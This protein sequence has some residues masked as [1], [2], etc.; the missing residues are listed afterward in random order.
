M[1]TRRGAEDTGSSGSLQVSG[2]MYEQASRRLG[3]AYRPYVIWG[4]PDFSGPLEFQ[5]WRG[6]RHALRFGAQQCGPVMGLYLK[7]APRRLR[8]RRDVRRDLRHL[9]GSS[10]KEKVRGNVR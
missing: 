8:P 2:F 1:P 5:T 6:G 4:A 3:D 10:R 9:R 7:P